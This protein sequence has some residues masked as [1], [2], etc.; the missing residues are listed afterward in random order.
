[1]SRRKVLWVTIAL[2]AVALLALG[3][4]VL[5]RNSAQT[6]DYSTKARLVDNGCVKTR[7]HGIAAG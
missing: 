6:P 4:Y 2:L 5:M 3:V 7:T 1:M